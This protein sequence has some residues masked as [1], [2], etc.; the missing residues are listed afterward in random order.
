[1]TVITPSKFENA[2]GFLSIGR[3][4]FATTNNKATTP[5]IRFSKLPNEESTPIVMTRDWNLAPF[6]ELF[7]NE[8]K[9]TTQSKPASFIISC[10]DE[11]ECRRFLYIVVEKLMLLGYGQAKYISIGYLKRND[12]L[13]NYETQRVE[14]KKQFSQLTWTTV[15]DF[16]S[17]ING[18]VVARIH[19]TPTENERTARYYVAGKYANQMNVYHGEQRNDFDDTLC[20]SVCVVNSKVIHGFNH[21]MHWITRMHESPFS[22]S[23]VATFPYTDR[24]QDVNAARKVADKMLREWDSRENDM[25]DA[26][27]ARQQAI[28][29]A[30]K[31]LEQVKPC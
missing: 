31:R 14:A 9:N 13:L 19:H 8:L 20:A 16:L 21:E 30:V 24:V 4:G 25:S 28:E 5:M 6:L 7:A 11:N 23:M 26:G 17:Q 1:M 3:G 15:E 22:S 10:A 27:R 29:G 18:F 12:R 2:T